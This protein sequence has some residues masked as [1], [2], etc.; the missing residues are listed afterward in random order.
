MRII[1]KLISPFWFFIQEIRRDYAVRKNVS[2]KKIKRVLLGAMWQYCIVLLGLLV[3]Y[4]IVIANIGITIV[5][6]KPL[7]LLAAAFP[8]LIIW[9]WTSFS[10]KFIV[11]NKREYL[12]KKEL[13]ELYTQ[14]SK[15][16]KNI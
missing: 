7:G 6:L 14:V 5:K 2:N 9:I 12:K 13:Y 3:L 1:K 16:I 4:Y 8:I 15:D 10:K 11:K